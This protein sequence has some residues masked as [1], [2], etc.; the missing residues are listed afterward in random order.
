VL[1]NRGPMTARMRDVDEHT[2]VGVSCPDHPGAPLRRFR[3]DGPQGRAV[4]LFCLANGSGIHRVSDEPVAP[5]RFP[6]RRSEGLQLSSE[7]PSAGAFGLSDAEL[8]VLKHAANGLTTA[9]TAEHLSKSAETVKTQR[10]RAILK[11]S[12]RNTTHAACRAVAHHLVELD[13]ER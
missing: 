2:Q 1:L 10:N 12:A 5:D 3:A 7:S 9:E 13:D 6:R 11:L 4:Y 8:E